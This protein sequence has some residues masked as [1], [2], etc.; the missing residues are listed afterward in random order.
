MVE[1]G[2][3]SGYQII[4]EVRDIL[5]SKGMHIIAPCPHEDKCPMKDNDWCHFSTRVQ[6]NKLHKDIKGGEAPFEDEKY[7]YIVLSKKEVSRCSHRI[8][9]HPIINKGMIKLTTC[10]KDGISNVEIRK[11]H[12]NYKVIKKL[13]VGDSY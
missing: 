12:P 4:K 9:R 3:P 10:S 8:L 6:R 2:T 11:N 7:S 13:K 1:P 5:L